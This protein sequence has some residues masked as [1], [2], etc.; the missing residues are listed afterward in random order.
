MKFVRDLKI[1]IHKHYSTHMNVYMWDFKIGTFVY[2]SMLFSQYSG[3]TY[4]YLI[5]LGWV[6]FVFNVFIGGFSWTW[7][8][9]RKF[10]AVIQYYTDHPEHYAAL[11]VQQTA[12][13]DSHRNCELVCS[14]WHHNYET[15]FGW[16]RFELII[17]DH[18]HTLIVYTSLRRKQLLTLIIIGS[19]T[20][21]PQRITHTHTHSLGTKQCN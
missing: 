9:S 2:S 13:Y 5:L 7:K 8:Y 4:C 17:T 21:S 16:F 6:S 10:H 1:C 11:C 15:H 19:H 18:Q 12:I 20:T 3:S 14:Y